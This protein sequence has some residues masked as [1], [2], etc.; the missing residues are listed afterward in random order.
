[1]NIKYLTALVSLILIVSSCANFLDVN[2]N[3]TAQKDAS[4]PLVLTASEGSLAFYTGSDFY[5]YSSIF[6]QQMCGQGSATQT[7]FYDQY[8]L[9]NTDVNNAFTNYYAGTLAD[10]NYIRQN[11]P[12]Q[13]NPQYAGVAEILQAYTYGTLVDMWGALPYSQALQAGKNKQPAYDSS[14]VIY[15]SLFALIDKGIVDLGKT[16]VRAIAAED[17]VYGGDISKW[18]KFANTLKL[19]L[20][21]HYAKADGGTMLNS[22]IAAA[23][24]NGGFMAANSDNFALAFDNVTN[25]QNPIHQFEIKRADYDFPGAFFVNLMNG[26]NDPRRPFYFTSYPAGAAPYTSTGTYK[27]AVST[28]A[29]GVAYSRIHTYLRGAL[30][31]DDGTRTGSGLKSTALTYDGKAPLRMLTFAEYNFI[32]AEAILSYGA[33]GS[34]NSFYQAGVKASMDDAGVSAANRDAYILTLTTPTLQTIIE[35][36][37]VASYGVSVEPWTD[38]RRTGFPAITISPAAVAQGNNTIPR[39]LVY[40]LSE[41]QVNQNNVPARASMAVK[42]VFWDK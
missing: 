18:K 14:K 13:G 41:Q 28:D 9:T 36:K 38:W 32:M 35:E 30:L 15:D 3:P 37:Y 2:V 27:G 19:R 34:A 17:L 10:L 31:S 11:A 42:G 40:P 20:A 22:V 4:V 7:R 8:I 33:T 39:I 6:T 26:K 24:A 16:N 1:M 23:T 29:T 12:N 21:L 5:L 25:R